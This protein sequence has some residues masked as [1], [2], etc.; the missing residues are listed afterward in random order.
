M[1]MYFSTCGYIIHLHLGGVCVQQFIN[2]KV[3]RIGYLAIHVVFA[4]TPLQLLY[5]LNIYPA[6]VTISPTSTSATEGMY[7]CTSVPVVT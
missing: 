5:P 3:K 7:M 1:C 4:V 6:Y 2:T